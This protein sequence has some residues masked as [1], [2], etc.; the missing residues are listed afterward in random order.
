MFPGRAA[1]VVGNAAGAVL[2]A[3]DT[4]ARGRKVVVSRGELVEIGGSFRIPEIM[5]RSGAGLVEVGTTNRTRI[6]DY[7]RALETEEGIAALL[8]VHPSNFRIVG[9]TESA[10]TRELAQLG[11]DF[12]IP[13]V[14]DFGSGNTVHLD[15]ADEPTIE[16]CLAAGPDL[17]IFSGDKLLGGPQAGVLLGAPEWI[18]RCRTNPLARAL[19]ADKTAIAGLVATLGSHASGQAQEEVPVLRALARPLEELRRETEALRDRLDPPPGWTVE[20]VAGASRVGGGAAPQAELPTV[21]LALSRT[22]LSAETIR[23]TLLS[24]DPPVAAR[25]R[26][27]MVLLDPRTLL[28][29]EIEELADLLQGLMAGLPFE[30]T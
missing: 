9:F 3:L 26:D 23:R 7:R 22:G 25:V 8:R 20:A 13:V 29:G 27:G 17:V 6:A 30:K 1:L 12:G 18:A 21:C 4:V 14:E 28:P 19:R 15:G 2:L 11:A 16:G 5:K 10:S 24:G